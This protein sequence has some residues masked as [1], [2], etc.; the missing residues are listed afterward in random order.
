MKK[1]A[2]HLTRAARDACA[3]PDKLRRAAEPKALA[4]AWL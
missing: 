1:A 2:V 3:D 4:S